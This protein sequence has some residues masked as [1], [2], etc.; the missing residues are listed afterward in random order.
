MQVV[1]G[2]LLQTMALFLLVLVQLTVTTVA[3]T[4]EALDPSTVTQAGGNF[5]Q[6][7]S[8][9]KT[10]VFF[11][12]C[13]SASSFASSNTKIQLAFHS[14]FAVSSAVTETTAPYMSNLTD[15]S[16][17]LTRKDD[18]KGHY[19]D[20]RTNPYA[21]F[22]RWP[23][24]TSYDRID[25]VFNME[26]GGAIA[27]AAFAAF[28]CTAGEISFED[29]HFNW[30]NHDNSGTA[31][32]KRFDN[33]AIFCVIPT[34]KYNDPISSGP[35]HCARASQGGTAT[36]TAVPGAYKY[37]VFMNTAEGSSNA[38][39][40]QPGLASAQHVI[41]RTQIF[42]DSTA[43]FNKDESLTSSTVGERDLTFL[44]VNG[45]GLSTIFDFTTH[46][47]YTSGDL[48]PDAARTGP[49]Q[50]DEYKG[51]STRVAKKIRI[52]FHRDGSDMYMDY[53]FDATDLKSKN[54]Y[55]V[56]DPAVTTTS[57]SGSS[58]STVVIVGIA[59]GA[60]VGVAL[61]IVGLMFA[62]KKRPSVGQA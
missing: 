13:K 48:P 7:Q 37:S 19:G 9:A 17:L 14:I 50:D 1:T 49:Q 12:G 42:T 35:D 36:Y 18:Q 59:I 29:N 52:K 6:G 31:D 8:S 26:K 2:L 61:L 25:T 39:S 33:T 22:T 30:Y 40:N 60:T 21:D 38:W 28:V 46:S 53:I 55:V 20:V 58:L 34:H 43:F 16:T 62:K 54:R 45:D 4:P 23:V 11:G 57:S 3:L 51:D 56:Y 44:T 27:N 24:G 32:Q 41:F 10:N 5:C 15:V 47:T